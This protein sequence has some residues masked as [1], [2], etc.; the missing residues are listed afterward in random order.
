[1]RRNDAQPAERIHVREHER[2]CCPDPQLEQNVPHP[3]REHR[4]ATVQVEIHLGDGAISFLRAV[5]HRERSRVPSAG[6]ARPSRTE[7]PA[8]TRA[9]S[10]PE[11]RG[12]SHQA[13]PEVD[14]R[15]GVARTPFTDTPRYRG[16]RSPPGPRA[17]CPRRPDHRDGHLELRV[18]RLE[19]QTHLVGFIEVRQALRDPA[20][21][22]IAVCLSIVGLPSPWLHRVTVGGETSKMLAM[23]RPFRPP[24]P[25][26]PR[27]AS[28]PR[29]PSLPERSW[30]SSFM[31][32]PA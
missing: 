12:L 24:S 6:P 21:C 23:S 20:S 13:H 11:V 16:V 22:A 7:R 18:G 14:R 9:T 5:E 1:M 28:I 4:L 8:R 27:R 29:F 26:G 31:P 19:P 3:G 30:W 32:V 2:P 17:S 10:C 25:S 15:G